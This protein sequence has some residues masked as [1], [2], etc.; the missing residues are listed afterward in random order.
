LLLRASFVTKWKQSCRRQEWLALVLEGGGRMVFIIHHN[1][2]FSVCGARIP[3]ITCWSPRT[4]TSPIILPPSL[5]IGFP[6]PFLSYWRL[7]KGVKGRKGRRE[8]ERERCSV[9]RACNQYLGWTP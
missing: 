7:G 8:T 1:L 9:G 3:Y 2:L 4:L 5:T 6:C